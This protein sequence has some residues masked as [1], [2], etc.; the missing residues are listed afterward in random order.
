MPGVSQSMNITSVSEAVLGSYRPE[1][2][3]RDK[4]S[5]AGEIETG[6]KSA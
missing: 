6:L 5:K 1:G 3:N 2:G 4:R